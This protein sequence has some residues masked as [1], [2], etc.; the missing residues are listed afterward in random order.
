MIL[1]SQLFLLRFEIFGSTGPVQVLHL[2]RGTCLRQTPI[3]GANYWHLVDISTSS[4]N[5]SA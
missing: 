3:F 4:N 1:L 5:C 2:H